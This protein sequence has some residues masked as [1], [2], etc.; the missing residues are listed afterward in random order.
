MAI[1]TGTQ[2]HLAGGALVP[3][4]T[5]MGREAF[6]R[7]PYGLLVL[8]GSGRVVCANREAARLIE[9]I[10]LP[11]AGLTCCAL[12]GC[13]QPDTVLEAACVTDLALGRGEALPEIR[14]DIHSPAGFSAMWVTAATIDD[15][16]ARV[17]L[18]LRPGAACDRRRRTSPHWMAGPRLRIRTLGRTVVEAVEGPIGGAWLDQR[19]GQ[20]LKYLV[21][22]RRRA[23]AVDEIGE[24]LW[25]G[26]DYAVGASVRYYVHAL[27]RK[28]E[29]Q[30]ALREPSSFVAG[31]SGTYRLRLDHVE[32]DADEFEAHLSAGLAL[33]GTDSPAAAAAIE[34]GLAIYRGDFLAD[35]PYAEWAM[36]E[37]HRLHDL[38]CVGLRRLAD[39]RLE[40]GL[41]EG[42]VHTLERLAALQ[43]FDEDVHRRLMELDIV[44]GR[45]SDAVRRYGALRSRIRQTFGHDPDFTLAD[46]ARQPPAVARRDNR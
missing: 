6:E 5:S 20:L 14:V 46:L 42:A 33:A 1:A 40:L 9:V 25:P 43:P 3:S 36:P 34:Q 13:R 15:A 41:L 22:E 44:R 32:V 26:A 11:E 39:I 2:T 23:A 27:R 35:L 8:D 7:F 31:R 21:A 19:T 16:G 45:R 30:R 28:L 4:R 38:A 10:G 12:L 37:R 17:V 29:P 18:Q 24:S